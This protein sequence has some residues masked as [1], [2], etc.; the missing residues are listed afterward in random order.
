LPIGKR[1]SLAFLNPDVDPQ[2]AGFSCLQS[3]IRGRVGG[4]TGVA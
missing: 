4:F 2:G 1:V 3:L